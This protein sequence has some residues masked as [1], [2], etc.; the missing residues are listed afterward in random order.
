MQNHDVFFISMPTVTTITA[1]VLTEKYNGK[2]T[3]L[4]NHK[5]VYEHDA[6]LNKHM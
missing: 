2:Q 5:K 3:A 4:I 6:W 1:S